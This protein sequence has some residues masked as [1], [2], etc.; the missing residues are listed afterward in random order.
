ML[1][2]RVNVK[3][4]TRDFRWLV[5]GNTVSAFGNAV[6][7]IAIL[8]LL[9]QLT[10]SA[11][12]LGLFQFLALLPGFVL[13]PLTGAVVDRVSR[14]AIII[15]TDIARGAI[16]IAAGA[17]LFLPRFQLPSL[18]LSVA[19]LAG[20][21]HALFVP[22][23]HAFIPT[24]V[25]ADRL[26]AASGLRAA[27]SQ[28]ANLVGNAVGGALFVLLGAPILFI[29]N[30]VTFLLSGLQESFIREGR[31][32]RGAAL[33]RSQRQSLL[34]EARG[35][36]ILLRQHAMLRRAIISQ[37]GLFAISSVLTLAMP[38]IVIDELGHSE[39]L[40]GLLFAVAL[41]GGII[42]F[43][44]Q[45][46]WNPAQMIEQPLLSYAYLAV[47]VGFFT[48]LVS[49]SL[50]ALVLVALLSGMAA[51][52]IY[53]FAVT[54]IQIQTPAG[55]HGRLFAVLEAASSFV[56][57]MSYLAAGALLDALDGSKRW[58]LFLGV[59]VLALL[60]AGALRRSPGAQRKP[61]S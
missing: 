27:S 25:P 59:G 11:L 45:R 13:S 56:A 42:A 26:H 23:V 5:A 30:G 10:D 39:S 58:W 46:R 18:L 32:L 1:R 21:G 48:L 36:L 52:T 8:L 22:A 3:V 6:Y 60:W 57:P 38:F 14:R 35:G 33:E 44:L 34:T 40:V 51:A 47:A 28:V 55:F 7:L 29:I 16:M 20:V 17:L 4:G 9:K 43:L 49:I 53:L 37:A 61:S 31:R 41:S 15:V 24:L 19:L 50:P 54:W 2:S 12:T